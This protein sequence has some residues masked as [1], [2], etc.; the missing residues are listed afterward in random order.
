M[1]EIGSL[2]YT[3]HNWFVTVI[4]PIGFAFMGLYYLLILF[5]DFQK[6]KKKGQGDEP[7]NTEIV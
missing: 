5:A 1:A 4:I 6:I 3:A 2:Y 7:E